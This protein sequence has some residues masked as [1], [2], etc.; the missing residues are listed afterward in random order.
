METTRCRASFSDLLCAVPA[1]RPLFEK[2]NNLFSEKNLWNHMLFRGCSISNAVNLEHLEGK[3]HNCALLPNFHAL[4]HY[5][6][7]M[8][9]FSRISPAR[10]KSNLT[11]KTPNEDTDIIVAPLQ[12]W[13]IL[14]KKPLLQVLDKSIFMVINSTF[15]GKF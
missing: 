13:H 1:R 4:F 11:L 5:T 6:T 10:Y 9:L 3:T 7:R 8:P 15:L 14:R 12:F 2:W